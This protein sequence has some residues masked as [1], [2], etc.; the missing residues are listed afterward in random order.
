[1]PDR[2]RKPEDIGSMP[3]RSITDCARL[4]DIRRGWPNRALCELAAGGAFDEP[5]RGA[6]YR[7]W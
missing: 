7:D 4:L 6:R 2:I 1:V 5:S 3:V